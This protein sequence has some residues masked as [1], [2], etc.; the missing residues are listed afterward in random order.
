M[1]LYHSPDCADEECASLLPLLP[2]KVLERLDV[3]PNKGM[4]EGWGVCFVEDWNWER[5]WG[6][7]FVLFGIGGLV[8]VVLWWA[9]EHDVQGASSM[10]A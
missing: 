3:C 6:L 8:F 4:S 2:K 7:G 10:A 1:H 5:V 9:L